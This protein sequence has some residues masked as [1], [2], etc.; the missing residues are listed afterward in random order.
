M[1]NNLGLNHTLNSSSRVTLQSFYIKKED[2]WGSTLK[3][4]INQYSC[5]LIHSGFKKKQIY[6]HIQGFE[7]NY[8]SQPIHAVFTTNACSPT[9]LF[10]AWKLALSPTCAKKTKCSC[11]SLISFCCFNKVQIQNLQLMYAKIHQELIIS[12]ILLNTKHFSAALA[13]HLQ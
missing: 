2:T 11:T 6:E 9:S 5:R 4:L 12:K 13:Q 3:V 8:Y 10:N 1:F 7:I